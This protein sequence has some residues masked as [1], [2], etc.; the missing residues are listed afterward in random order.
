MIEQTN[1]FARA[2]MYGSLW[3]CILNKFTFGCVYFLNVMLMNITVLN[4]LLM[5]AFCSDC[6]LWLTAMLL[7]GVVVVNSVTLKLVH[8][9]ITTDF[10]K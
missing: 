5:E 7:F 8:L 4:L 10:G 6:C 3:R 2:I 1:Y 9:W